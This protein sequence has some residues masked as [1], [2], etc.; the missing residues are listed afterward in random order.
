MHTAVHSGAPQYAFIS[1][2][3]LVYH[4]GY[5]WMPPH[6]HDEQALCCVRADE[7]TIPMVHEKKS[8]KSHAVDMLR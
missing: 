1:Q 4:T 5:F 6:G 3:T 2:N 7:Q 8:G